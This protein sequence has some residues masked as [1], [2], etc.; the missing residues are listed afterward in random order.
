MAF[1]F[2][3]ESKSDGEV[4]EVGEGLEEGEQ[5]LGHKGLRSI[6]RDCERDDHHPEVGYGLMIEEAE[7][8]FR[9]GLKVEDGGG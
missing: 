8:I 4:E 5:S 6:S 7:E 9:I 2:V 1:F 3:E